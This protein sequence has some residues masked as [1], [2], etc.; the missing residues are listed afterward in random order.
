MEGWQPIATA[1]KD[2]TEIWVNGPTDVDPPAGV[3]WEETNG[4]EFWE[5]SYSATGSGGGN[6]D[7]F[8]DWLPSH[9]MSVPPQPVDASSI[10]MFRNSLKEREDE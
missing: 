6:Y 3:Y 1:P 5:L 2:G 4:E 8:I 9:W 10:P 7:L